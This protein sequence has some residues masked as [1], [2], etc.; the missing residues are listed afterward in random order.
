MSNSAHR[1]IVHI[2]L[3]IALI[4]GFTHA[5]E[6]GFVDLFNGRDLTGFDGDRK[7]WSV[8]DGAIVGQTSPTN[9]TKGTY[10]F[11]D[12]VRAVDFE[13][14]VDF[15]L[16]SGNSGIQYRSVQKPDWQ[17]AG[18][19]ADMDFAGKYTG[20][21][22][23]CAGRAIMTQPGDNVVYDEAGKVTPA[24][25]ST[26]AQQREGV[27]HTAPG[28]WNHYVIIARGDHVVHQIN[29]V[30]FVQV[31]DRDARRIKGDRIAFQ[32]HPGPPM[33]VMFKNIRIKAYDS[34]E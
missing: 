29:G 10:L 12:G 15:Q 5:G 23:E 33:K 31:T 25:E 30:T 27:I 28:K 2:A 9:T 34:K 3:L 13:L 16:P 1:H 18:Y 4:A 6:S 8:A 17:V 22:Y 14:H 21:L 32:L 7:F 11:V 26:P 24:G 20:I 19:Q